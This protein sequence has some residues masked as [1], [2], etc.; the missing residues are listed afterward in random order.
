ML[1][2]TG[3]DPNNHIQ[4]GALPIANGPIAME[5]EVVRRHQPL[6]SRIALRSAIGNMHG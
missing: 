1:A 2:A 4:P 6:I 3:L 5:A